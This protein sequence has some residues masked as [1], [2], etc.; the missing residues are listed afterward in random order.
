[1]TDCKHG[2]RIRIKDPQMQNFYLFLG[3]EKDDGE[4]TVDGSVDEIWITV[5]DEN[6]DHDKRSDA[7]TM[8]MLITTC[9][10]RGV[11]LDELIE[12]MT[13]CVH[14]ESKHSISGILLGALKDYGFPG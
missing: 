12:R 3:Y 7:R 2:K 5:P 9:R 1:M 11:E 4:F 6:K 10:K 8:A 13:E 14:P